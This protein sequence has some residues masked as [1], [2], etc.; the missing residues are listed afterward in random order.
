[1]QVRALALTLCVAYYPAVSALFLDF[2]PVDKVG[3]VSGMA[4]VA[5]KGKERET[6][7]CIFPS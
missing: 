4:G 5:V 7:P 2:G 6:A 3:I 1:M